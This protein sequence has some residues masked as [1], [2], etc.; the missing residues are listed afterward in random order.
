MTLTIPEWICY[1]NHKII[2]LENRPNA[3]SLLY[4]ES[5]PPQSLGTNGDLYIQLN[6][7]FLYQKKDEL[8]ESRGVIQVDAVEGGEIL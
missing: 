4:G 5:S 7:G 3:G 6:G 8:W 2:E 1:L